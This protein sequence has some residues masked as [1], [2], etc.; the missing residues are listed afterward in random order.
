MT[1]I[2]GATISIIGFIILCWAL[3]R[4][5]GGTV[6]GICPNASIFYK[7]PEK[8]DLS[9]C[10][11]H[12]SGSCLNS[13]QKINGNFLC[14]SRVKP[15]F[16]VGIQYQSQKCNNILGLMSCAMFRNDSGNFITWDPI[17]QMI[18]KYKICRSFCD[19][20]F[21]TCSTTKEGL[22]LLTWGERYA[23]STDFCNKQFPFT[24]DESN[25]ACFNSGSSI[26]PY[27]FLFIIMIFL[28]TFQYK[29]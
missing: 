5:L 10:T 23:N 26:K 11:W 9:C 22:S 15:N 3:F 24:I 21:Q 27:L 18:T 13:G 17:K 4:P 16:N 1:W 25:K 19:E 2:F 12:N 6:D 29:K 8:S 14:D 7:T 20:L 28:Q